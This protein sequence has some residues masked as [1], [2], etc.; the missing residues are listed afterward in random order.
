MFKQTRNRLLMS[1]TLCGISSA[2]H[3]QAIS[4]DWFGGG[5]GG[6]TASTMMA[7]SETAGLIPRANWNSF[8]PEVQATP[9][10]LV[11]SAGAATA[12]TVSWTSANTW[13]INITETPGDAKM[14]RGYL[15]TN[16]T[17]VTTVTVSGVPAGL[18][19]YA[20]I[21]YYD[22]DTGEQRVGRYQLAGATTGNAT[23]WGRDNEVNFSGAFTLGQTPVDPLA[24][25]GAIDSNVAAAMTVPAGN[26]MIFPDVTGSDFTLTAT[27]SVSEGG[28]NRAPL[29]AIQIVPMAQVPEPGALALVGLLGAGLFARH[30]R[31]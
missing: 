21:L 23:F 27:A 4:I 8:T 19:P 25:G 9:Q 12:A 13:N 24:G 29:N 5:G 17:S 26:V 16:D 20:V 14:M 28:T 18:G 10:P 7:P 15:D 31:A 2:A 1:A 11:N 6:G 22:G 30:R 3:G